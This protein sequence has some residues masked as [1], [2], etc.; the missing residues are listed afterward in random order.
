MIP[1]V[2]WHFCSASSPAAFY[3]IYW[4]YKMGDKLDRARMRNNIPAGSFPIL[5][6]VLNIFG[7]SIVTCA[8]IQ[9]ELNHYTPVQPL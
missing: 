4:G 7:L 9:S 2:S 1:P 3:S 5:F 6:L 8:I